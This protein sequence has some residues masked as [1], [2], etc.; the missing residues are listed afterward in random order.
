M[1]CVR[2]FW[3]EEDNW[4][5]FELDDDNWVARQVELQGPDQ[6]PTVAASLAEWQTERDAGRTSQYAAQFGDV[7]DQPIPH[8]DIPNYEVVSAEKFEQVWRTARARLMN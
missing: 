6:T 3:D 7:A 8:D 2:R 1:R 5:Y 4:F